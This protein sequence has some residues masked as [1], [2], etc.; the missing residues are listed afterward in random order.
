[1][2]SDFI[3]P[4]FEDVP[5]YARFDCEGDCYTIA[6]RQIPTTGAVPEPSIVA[7]FAAGLFGIGFARRRKA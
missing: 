4:D 1:V 2:Y 7:L 5:D 6:L 3:L